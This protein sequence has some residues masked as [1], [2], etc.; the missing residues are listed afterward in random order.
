MSLHSPAPRPLATERSPWLRGVLAMA[1]DRA[2]SHRALILGA[3]A[4]GETIIEGLHESADVFATGRAMQA[5]GARIE[6]RAGR[7]HIMGIGVGGF[8]E[9]EDVLHFSSSTVA[10]RLVMGLVGPYGFTSHFAGDPA[11]AGRSQA[12]VL[13]AL[14]HFG[15]GVVEGGPDRLPFSLRG[16]RLAT[17]ADYRM[18]APS[19]LLKSAML[20]GALPIAGVTTITEPLPT[21]DH[22][23]RMLKA[24]GARL[25]M[26]ATPEGGKVIEIEGLANLRAQQVM[27]PGD[28]SAAAHAIV[29]GLIVP[30]SEILIENVLVSPM[31][32][33]LIDTL[34]EMGG[35]I[36]LVRPR[37]I[38]GEDV[39]DIRVIQSPLRGVTVPAERV[40]ALVEE[41]PL[42]A[43]AAAAAEGKTVIQGLAA[44][45]DRDSDQVQAV[46]NGLVVNR[47]TVEMG[48]DSLT[49]HG[50][51]KIKGG[52]RAVTHGDAAIAMAFLVLG[53]AADE[54]VTVDDQ[55]A[56]AQTYPGFIQD[57]ENL[58][59]SFLRYT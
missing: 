1:G 28:A 24:F 57:F 34:R 49:I 33:G 17:P 23:E 27:V 44:L 22:T 40:P 41:F 37:K 45:R 9:P 38:G 42:L 15:V 12:V 25:E 6:R 43:V 20:L 29:A 31:R 16:A 21:R 55:S 47:T 19:A 11:L 3:M 8:L 35:Q 56:I 7:W 46:T 58:G 2:I 32:T 48:E 54:Q 26:Q 14:Q 36:D 10:L 18:E 52:G 59:A 30:H 13:A 51:G 50:T 53:M 39:A 4:R 5:L